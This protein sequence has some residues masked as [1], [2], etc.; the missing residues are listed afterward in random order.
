MDT[1]HRLFV[2][3]ASRPWAFRRDLAVELG[4][5]VGRL[6]VEQAHPPVQ[7][8]MHQGFTCRTAI[9]ADDT[10]PDELDASVLVI[11]VTAGPFHKVGRYAVHHGGTSTLGS[12]LPVLVGPHHFFGGWWLSATCTDSTLC[13]RQPR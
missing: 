10:G 2:A 7:D 5:A 1:R 9:G 6:R 12:S 13:R 3:D 8:A 11:L 4:I